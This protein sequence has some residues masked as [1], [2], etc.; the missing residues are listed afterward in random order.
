LDTVITLSSPKVITL[1]KRKCFYHSVCRSCEELGARF[2]VQPNRFVDWINVGMF[3]RRNSLG[4]PSLAGIPPTDLWKTKIIDITFYVSICLSVFLS[5]CLSVFQSF[6]LSVFQSF[7][8]SVFLSFCLSVSLSL[9][10]SVSLSSS[11]FLFLCV[12]ICVPLSTLFVCLS[13][14]VL[15]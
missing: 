3:Q 9:C 13:R 11:L 4:I 14:Y 10:L 1:S 12:F 8:L 15:N 7:T 2:G 5:F 6:S